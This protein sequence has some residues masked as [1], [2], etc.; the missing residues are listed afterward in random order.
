MKFGNFVSMLSVC[1][2]VNKPS[3]LGIITLI[4]QGEVVVKFFCNPMLIKLV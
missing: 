4:L 2:L 1:Q 3:I